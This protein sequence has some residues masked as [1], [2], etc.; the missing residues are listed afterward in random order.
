MSAKRRS[1]KVVYRRR[2]LAVGC[3][4]LILLAAVVIGI[5][6]GIRWLITEKPWENLPFVS[7]EP[8]AEETVDPTPTVYPTARGGGDAEPT[9]E[10]TE[11]PEP[12]A[13]AA[14]ALELAAVTN[15]TEYG[16]DDD[17]KLAM[18]LTNVGGVDCVVNVGTTVQRFEISSGADVW[19]RSSDCQADPTDQWVTL[20]AG[21]TVKSEE[22]L[23]WDRT[24]SYDNTCDA[25]ERPSAPA[26]ATY[27]LT[28]TLGEVSSEPR[29][30][31]L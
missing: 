9:P 17:P 12:E 1:S 24:R 22:A 19:W 3:L 2:R 23:V 11:E 8:A 5:V 25:D 30:F 27:N 13:C 4:T 28:V 20:E 14:G 6:F 26:G 16:A 15:K 10:A 31:T 7:G 18:S 29:S 21:Q